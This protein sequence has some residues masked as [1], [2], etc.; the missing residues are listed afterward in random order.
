[1]TWRGEQARMG[2][3]N[4]RTFPVNSLIGAGRHASPDHFR[5]GKQ[6]AAWVCGAAI[7]SLSSCAPAF[8][9]RINLNKPV[10]EIPA[11]YR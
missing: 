9:K 10:A 11:G 1:M 2:L 3:G 7:L 5:G 4:T 8:A 6:M